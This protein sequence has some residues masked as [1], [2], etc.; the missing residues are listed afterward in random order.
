MVVKHKR[1]HSSVKD[2][3]G[4]GPQGTILALLLFLVMINDLGFENQKNNAGEL[5]TCKRNLKLANEIKKKVDL[6]KPLQLYRLYAT[7]KP[8]W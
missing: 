2:L 1:G 6:V 4:G 5:V 7:T 3:P 8:K